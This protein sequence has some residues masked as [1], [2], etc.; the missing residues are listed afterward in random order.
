MDAPKLS[1]S[2][3]AL[4]ASIVASVSMG[5]LASGCGGSDPSTEPDAQGHVS[6]S[7]RTAALNAEVT[8]SL[9]LADRQDFE[10][11]E[12]GLVGRDPAVE[13]TSTDGRSIWNSREYDFVDGD[14]PAS[15]NPS[16]WR[17]AKLNGLHGLYEV[18]DGVY[19]VR[20]YDLSNMTLI[21]GKTGWIVVDPL[22]SEETAAAA[23]A[24]A[25]RHLGDAPIV[26]VIFTHSHIDHFGGIEAVL[27]EDDAARAKIR[28]IAPEAFLEE[29]TSENVLAGIAMGRRA[30]F[31]Y[32]VPLARSPRGHVDTGLGKQP[33]RG[34]IAIA[35]PTDI[36]DRTP[37]EMDIDGVRFVFQ[38]VP[39]SEAPSELAFYLPEKK[40]YG[41]AEIVSHT[42]HNLYT[43]R[44]AKVRDALLWSDYID[45]AARRF[46]DA[47]V[48]FASHHW[49][50]WGN[51]RVLDYLK[52]QRD[53]YRYLHDQTLRLA[54]DGATPREIAE[55]LELPESL[56]RFFANRGY[57]GTVRHNAKAV[58]QN[59]F[60]WYDGNPA[61]LDPLP[62]VD[63]AKRYVAAMGGAD[64]V[65]RK[66]REAI[67]QG[68]ERWA[69]ELLNHLVFADPDD[70][71]AREALASAYDQLGYR[72]ESGPW[73]DVYLTAA[74]ELRHGTQD[75][76]I[77]PKTAGELLRHLPAD[78]FFTAMATRLNGP[79]AD[80]ENLKINF[81]FTDLGETHVVT[82]ENSVLH[83]HRET[84][85]DP[86]AN[87]TIRLTRDFLVRMVTGQA[88]L[89]DMIFSDE[90][91]VDG[92][93]IDLMSFFS[94]LDRPDGS[95]PIVTP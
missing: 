9:P 46:G 40:A 80:G 60:G 75:S 71:A 42:M 79:D 33:A 30:G 83:H 31:M 37:Q 12:R 55:T 14:A 58:Y 5:I 25:R 59:Y 7:A 44:G 10:D 32:G 15:V 21:R 63:A 23:L 19:Q 27:P 18:T 4:V 50:V 92:S 89:R 26:A 68:D 24:L 11:A 88:G 70:D 77:D 35:E 28:V 94:L 64:E 48:V 34:T 74:Y 66:G 16:L 36:V 45:E 2:R 29:A 72:A 49:P 93:R 1:L 84:E 56:A 73:R 6:P 95:F 65:L 47:E 69:A 85:P 91:S 82:L 90:L 57:Y 52:K 39:N 62:P 22:T 76:P 13:V 61:N 81:V 87:A 86:E 38:Y 43:L 17:Q 54:N 67:E 51:D 20:G 8:T 3:R 41:G 53:A 78:R